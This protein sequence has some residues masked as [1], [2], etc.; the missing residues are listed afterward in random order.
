MTQAGEKFLAIN[1]IAPPDVII[2]AVAHE[3]GH[4]KE[5]KSASDYARNYAALANDISGALSQQQER[6]AD[7]YAVRL[8]QGQ[9]LI[10]ALQF[11]DKANVVDPHDTSH[12][13]IA[14]RIAAIDTALKGLNLSQGQLNDADYG[15]KA[16]PSTTAIQPTPGVKGPA[17]R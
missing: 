12:P 13:S 16:P 10:A 15:N 17:P 9:K 4:L 8:G 1:Q 7:M 5:M 3:F 14:S 11:Y 2:G 6:A